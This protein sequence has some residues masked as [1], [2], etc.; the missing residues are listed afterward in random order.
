[1]KKLML[2]TALIAAVAAPQAFAQAKHFEG[3]SVFGGVNV[4]NSTFD[5]TLTNG[6]GSASATS[7]ATNIALQAQYAWALGDQFVLGV[8]ATVGAG[9][10]LF[11]TWGG[12][13]GDLKLKDTA[14]VYIAPGIAVSDSTLLYGKVASTSGTVYDNS[15][16]LSVAGVG[17]G[18][19]AQFKSGNNLFY[20]VEFM[21]NNYNNKDYATWTDKFR[22][23]AI[24]FGVGYKF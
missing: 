1:M 18:L 7:R 16:S 19:G 2:A 3:F 6:A 11:G 13:G 4:A 10:L 14:A 24:S 23:S 22:T 5:R 17:Y 20:Q 15:G 21:Q 9:D 12:S 8:G